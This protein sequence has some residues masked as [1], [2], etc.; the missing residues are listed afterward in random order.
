MWHVIFQILEFFSLFHILYKSSEGRIVGA[1]L[2][3][4]FDFAVVD[5]IPRPRDKLSIA[6]HARFW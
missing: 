5:T 4:P 1:P 3:G 6:S 2:I